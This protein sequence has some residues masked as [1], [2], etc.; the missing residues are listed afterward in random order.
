MPN[1][2]NAHGGAGVRRRCYGPRWERQLGDTAQADATS[3]ADEVTVDTVQAGGTGGRHAY[4]APMLAD[5]Y[6]TT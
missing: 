1:A 5:M 2:Q 4:D 6:I 3:L